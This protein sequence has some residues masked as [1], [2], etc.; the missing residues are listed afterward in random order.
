MLTT[1]SNFFVREQLKIALIIKIKFSLLLNN[2]PSRPEQSAGWGLGEGV[3]EWA[4]DQF[5]RTALHT[6]SISLQNS[7]CESHTWRL[8]R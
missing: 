3:D 6:I 1:A 5:L 2:F 8:V 7:F 4:G